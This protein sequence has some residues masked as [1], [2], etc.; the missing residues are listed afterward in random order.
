MGYMSLSTSN[1]G[2][3]TSPGIPYGTKQKH[4]AL[5]L[6]TANI[7][8]NEGRSLRFPT[9]QQRTYNH[10][11]F[12]IDRQTCKLHTFPPMKEGASNSRLYNTNSFDHS[13]YLTKLFN[14]MLRQILA[15]HNSAVRASARSISVAARSITT[16]RGRLSAEATV[17]NK[18]PNFMTVGFSIDHPVSTDDLN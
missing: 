6:Q 8:S 3:K 2:K 13:L 10:R 15:L 18:A 12:G 5:N 16:P 11:L 9:K 7:S 4:A 1:A 17:K 14:T